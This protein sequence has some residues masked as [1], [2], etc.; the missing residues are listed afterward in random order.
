MRYYAVIR[1]TSSVSELLHL[2][3]FIDPW[4]GRFAVEVNT[5]HCV[6]DV[7]KVLL[8]VAGFCILPT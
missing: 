7:G 6:T 4:C 3:C 5:E 2:Q 8:R 1:S